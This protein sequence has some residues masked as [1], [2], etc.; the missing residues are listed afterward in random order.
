MRTLLVLAVLYSMTSLA[1]AKDVSAQQVGVEYARENQA[2]AETEHKGNLQRVAES[3]K[4]LADA[5]K[6]LVEDRQKTEA[7]KK[8]LDEAS[9]KFLR[10]QELLDKAWKE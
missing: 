2:K 8:K 3:E 7:S 6:R 1:Q 10:A 4:N 9:A 5:Q